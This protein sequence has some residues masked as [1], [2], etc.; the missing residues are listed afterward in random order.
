MF[1]LT[2]QHHRNDEI[3]QLL[4]TGQVS[5]GSIIDYGYAVSSM[6]NR[7]YLNLIYFILL[8]LWQ[9]IHIACRYN[10]MYAVDILVSRGVP[11]DLPD[12]TA[13]TGLHYAARYGH[14][15][16]EN[17]NENRQW[18]QK[19]N[20]IFKGVQIHFATWGISH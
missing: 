9:D 13:N 20:F 18:Q 3:H 7:Y 2:T 12:R 17:M 10:N 16:V 8:V 6:L 4:S 19:C 5:C 14:I 1:F 15:E 11:I